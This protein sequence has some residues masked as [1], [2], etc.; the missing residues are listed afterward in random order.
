MLGEN[1]APVLFPGTDAVG[2]DVMID[3]ADFSRDWRG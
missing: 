1:V 3:G 2:K